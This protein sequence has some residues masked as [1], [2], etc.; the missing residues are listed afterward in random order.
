MLKYPFRKGCSLRTTLKTVKTAEEEQTTV[1]RW[2]VQTS[3]SEQCLV[4]RDETAMGTG[5][6]PKIQELEGTVDSI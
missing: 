4:K 2:Q 6:N 3:S 1:C 5:Q